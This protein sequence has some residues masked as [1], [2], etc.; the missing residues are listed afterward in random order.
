ML[1]FHIL[2]VSAAAQAAPATKP[3]SDFSSYKAG[4]RRQIERLAEPMKKMLG[5]D[6][7]ESVRQMVP[8]CRKAKVFSNCMKKNE[9]FDCGVA[10]HCPLGNTDEQKWLKPN[11]EELA[12]RYDEITKSFDTL[13]KERRRLAL[14]TLNK[15]IDLFNEINLDVLNHPHSEMEKIP[16]V[17]HPTKEETPDNKV[18]ACSYQHYERIYRD[19]ANR[20]DAHRKELHEFVAV[21]LPA[22]V[23]SF[24]DEEKK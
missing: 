1:I 20:L 13:P 17:C 22:R 11:N 23:N 16:Q 18:L 12:K 21:T 5:A 10:L 14:G 8:K 4:V 9:A 24:K 2:A 7:A 19:M 15:L 6:R 3:G